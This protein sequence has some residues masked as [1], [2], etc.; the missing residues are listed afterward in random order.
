MDK[1]VNNIGIFYQLNLIKIMLN[2]LRPIN[3][4]HGI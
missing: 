3:I 4:W 2:V 1:Q